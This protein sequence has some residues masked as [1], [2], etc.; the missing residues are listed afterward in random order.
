MN[1]VLFS[2]AAGW[3][4]FL[5]VTA[6]VV[7]F[8][9]A[10]AICAQASGG[11]VADNQTATSTVPADRPSPVSSSTVPSSVLNPAPSGS[12][13]A[14]NAK[15]DSGIGFDI[16]QAQFR[17]PASDYF[18]SYRGFQGG[19][20]EFMGSGQPASGNNRLS[21]AGLAGIEGTAGFG[22]QGSGLKP[23][24]SPNFNQM[25]R[26]NLALPFASS[27]GTFKLTY[28]D[29]LVPGANVGQGATGVLFTTTNLGNGVF[30]SAGTNLGK[31]SM[32]GTPPGGN[33]GAN[34]PKP[35][36][37]AVALKLSF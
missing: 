29:M 27:V 24:A 1:R 20:R 10:G 9:G 7:L 28:R 14:A 2:G 21:G 4:S 8:A 19:G 17:A 37:P 30:F 6:G 15:D 36:R 16:P 25:M 33:A 18:Q 3:S 26:T 22:F 32:A 23:G 5:R 34:G 31:G 11:L 13:A 35:S 12:L